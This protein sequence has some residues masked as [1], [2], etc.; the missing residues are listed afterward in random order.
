MLINEH[1]IVVIYR[2]DMLMSVYMSVVTYKLDRF[3]VSSSIL[4]YVFV[5]SQLSIY[6]WVTV[7]G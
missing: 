1:A 5:G 7:T 6:V 2:F 3:P 4:L